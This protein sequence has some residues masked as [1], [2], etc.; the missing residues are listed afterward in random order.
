MNPEILQ[1]LNKD[2]HIV[3]TPNKVYDDEMILAIA[4]DKNA[5]VISND[6]F[7]EFYNDPKIGPFLQGFK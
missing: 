1:T 4:V 6:R 2:G 7:R 5:V 3:F